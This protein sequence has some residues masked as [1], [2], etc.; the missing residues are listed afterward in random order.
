IAFAGS[1]TEAVRLVKEKLGHM[2]KLEVET[3]TE[4]QVQEAIDAGAD[5]IMFDNRSP[6]EVTLFQRLVPEHITTEAS[7]NISL[8]TLHSYRHTGVDYISLGFLTHS[9]KS[10]D[11]SLTI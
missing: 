3:E 4:E 9:V 8:D 6:E 5:I 1:I 2:V 7:G 11:I 10:L